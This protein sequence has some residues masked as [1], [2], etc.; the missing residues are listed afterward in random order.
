VEELLILQREIAEARRTF[1]NSEGKSLSKSF[2][3]KDDKEPAA[4]EKKKEKKGKKES[5]STAN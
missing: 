3:E 4:K 5:S 1:D 2:I